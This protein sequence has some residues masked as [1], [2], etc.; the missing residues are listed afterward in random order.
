MR[1]NYIRFAAL[2]LLVFSIAGVLG[3]YQTFADTLIRPRF[4][5]IMPQL[6]SDTELISPGAPPQAEEQEEF[7]S[8]SQPIN[9]SCGSSVNFCTGGAFEDI[10]D[11]S[12][13]HLWDCKGIHGGNSA[14]CRFGKTVPPQPPSGEPSPPPDE[15]PPP[16]APP[17]SLIKDVAARIRSGVN[18]LGEFFGKAKTVF[19]P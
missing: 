13:F 2:L 7:I 4:G 17:T 5:E 14:S 3:S 16:P 15:P 6:P 10:T 1:K 8:P 12:L 11:S 19:F 9:G 18:A